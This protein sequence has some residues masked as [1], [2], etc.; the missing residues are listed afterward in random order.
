[1]RYSSSLTIWLFSVGLTAAVSLH[2]AQ[3]RNQ[4]EQATAGDAQESA[5]SI[6]QE[7]EAV[8]GMSWDAPFRESLIKRLT[9]LSPEN[10]EAF[11]LAQRA[12]GGFEPLLGDAR[13]DQVYTPVTPCRFVDGINASDRV[14]AA[15]NST[16][17]RWYRVRGTV[18][19][20]F[21]SQG[22]SGSAP[23][24]CGIPVSATAVVLNLT[25]A[26]PTSDGDLKADPS[27]LPPS[28]TSALNYTFGGA[29]GKNLANAAVVPL[30]DLT[31]STCASGAT[32]ATATRDILVTFHAGASAVGTYFLAD[33]V[34][35]FR[36][37]PLDNLVTTGCGSGTKFAQLAPAQCPA[38]ATVGIPDCSQ[39]GAGTLCEYTS[40][41]SGA[42]I[43][44]DDGVTPAAFSETLN[45]CA[46]ST[47]W[48]VKLK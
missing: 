17:S 18:S 20:D 6:V 41:C 39:V 32:P 38:W 10:R 5:R 7:R 24:G 42:T 28:S 40:G 12:G 35:Y 4:A 19:T 9:S 46:G 27:H 45:N 30:C 47:D 21:V 15:P 36:P 44:A 13:I 34:G 3:G 16:T 8:S 1:V 31:V 22:A 11:A 23:N 37:A 2:A 25:V 14:S 33:V 26:D 48:Y 43:Y 29:R